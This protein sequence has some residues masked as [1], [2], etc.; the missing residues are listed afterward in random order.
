MLVIEHNEHYVNIHTSKWNL[1]RHPRS[2]S[3]HFLPSLAIVKCYEFLKNTTKV[4]NK[5]TKA[6]Y[7][8]L[9]C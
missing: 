5:R 7:A 4:K 9:I 2:V 3:Y 6:A 1:D 8:L